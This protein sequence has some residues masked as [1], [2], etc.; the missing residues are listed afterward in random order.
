VVEFLSP[1]V[2]ITEVDSPVQGIDGVSTSNMGIAGFTLK[3]PAA[4]QMPRLVTSFEQF[5]RE[6]GGFT[7]DSFLPLSVAGFFQNGGRRAFIQRV[8]PADATLSEAKLQS[9]TTDQEV[10]D[11]DG[12]VG[13][14]TVASG[15]TT[16][17]V[18]SGASP[19]VPGQFNLRWRAASASTVSGEP[20]VGRDDAALVGD[21]SQAT[22]EGQIR[23]VLASGSI[24]FTGTFAGPVADADTLLL[25]DGVT[26]ITLEYDKSGTNTPSGTNV[27]VDVS[28]DATDADHA[29]TTAAV[30]NG[31]ANLNLYADVTGAVITLY[32]LN[33]GTVGN[34]TTWAATFANV[35]PSVTQPTGGVDLAVDNAQFLMDPSATLAITDGTT[36]ISSAT[37]Q[38]RISRFV[39][40]I[41]SAGGSVARVDYRTGFV[42]IT[43][44][45]GEIPG[46]AA[47]ITASYTP[48]VDKSASDVA[49]DGVLTG[50][51]LTSSSVDYLTGA[52]TLEWGAATDAPHNGATVNEG[53]PVLATYQ[54]DA[55][56]L[57]PVSEG[58]WGNDLRVV[59]SGNVDSFTASTGTYSLFDVSVQSFNASTGGF[60]VSET[61][62][63]LD[64]AD[65]TSAQ[66]FADVINELSDLIRVTEPAGDEAIGQLNAV[67]RTSVVGAGDDGA[68]ASSTYTGTLGD[69]PIQPRTVSITWT[70]N[71]G[72]A[73]TITDDGNGTLT[74]DI[75]ATGNNTINYSTGAYDFKIFT[76]GTVLGV[77]DQT[78]IEAAYATAPS[79]SYTSDFG[80]TTLYTA[81]TGAS[82]VALS[83]GV[84][85]TFDSTNYGR[86]QFTVP[87]LETTTDGIYAFNKI[88]EILQLVVP[89]FAGDVTITRDLL[90]YADGRAL[91]SQGADRFVLLTVP[92]NS[93]PQEAV[94]WFRFDLQR[95]TKYAALYAPWI[96]VA[97]PL[98][99]N[100]PLSIPPMA[101]VAGIYARTDNAKNVS[102]APGGTIDGQLRG[103]LSLEQNWTQGE[104]DL[105]YPNKINP[106]ISSTPTG[107]AVWGVRTISNQT[108]W[109][110]VNVVRL[111]QFVEQSIWRD[112][113]WIVFESNNAALRLRIRGQLT[114]F[115]NGLFASGYFAGNRPNEAFSVTVDESN[116]PPEVVDQGLVV[117]DV[118]IAPL[119]PAEFVQFRFAQK[120]VATS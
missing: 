79:S 32:V 81:D 48:T 54:I 74:G 66:Y 8:V 20:M 44:D 80:D 106:L 93:S 75:D 30:I 104:R 34:V 67:P 22:F 73:R 19:L 69:T 72:T 85:G 27:E 37:T 117:I 103:L 88:E 100:R 49:R 110:Y 91:Q 21:A 39:Y 77:Q 43:W 105:V 42:S 4:D 7:A 64:F 102:K 109:R 26:Q 78:F 107:L 108:E 45:A 120:S 17:K 61:Y 82:A 59:V 11:G 36:T 53:A 10:L 25:D 83:E 86:N 90:D 28:G 70:D 84:D 51:G 24:D 50:S 40:D 101:H 38:T 112:T 89:D 14:F 62:E 98:T 2:F 118:A 52:Y 3:G 111:F 46:A 47:L 13:P 92:Q 55:W 12:T 119:K 33:P 57:D 65:N 35:A 15:A 97:D 114:G 6:F 87:T 16:L 71:T 68:A 96:N 95:F 5:N 9:T 23:P 58:A 115:L 18:N 41:E 116:N 63:A 60:D 29:T 31:L 1:G 99:D 113:Q 76:S 56:D 94:D